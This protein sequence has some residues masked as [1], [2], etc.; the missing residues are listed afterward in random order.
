MPTI[1][2]CSQ[3]AEGSERKA[4]HTPPQITQSRAFTSFQRSC[5]NSHRRAERAGARQGIPA[6]SPLPSQWLDA[7]RHAAASKAVANTSKML[8]FA[9]GAHSN[10]AYSSPLGAIQRS[11]ATGC[12][13]TWPKTAMVAWSGPV[14]RAQCTPR[15]GRVASLEPTQCSARSAAWKMNAPKAASTTGLAQGRS[16]RQGRVC[17]RGAMREASWCKAEPQQAPPKA[18]QLCA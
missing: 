9:C 3:D 13:P 17:C 18:L 8:L 10:S 7:E 6:S 14:T 11:G 16:P 1:P 5:F 2:Q 12:H 4:V 15:K